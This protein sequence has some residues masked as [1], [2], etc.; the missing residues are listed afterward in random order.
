MKRVLPAWLLVLGMSLF[1]H[2][3]SAEPA[4]NTNGTEYAIGGY[5]VVA[6]FALQRAVRGNKEHKSELGG[7]TWLFA[8]AEHK[9]AFDK[10]PNKYLPAYRGYCAYGVSRGNL[11]K[12]APEAFTL[13]G[14]KL[15]LNYSLEVRNTWLADPDGYIKKANQNW[16][17]L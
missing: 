15:Y 1:S 10:A 13:R 11:V 8:S 5:D 4:I 6:Y 17:K 3:A 9:A 2:S 12:I 7:A 14:G 16:P